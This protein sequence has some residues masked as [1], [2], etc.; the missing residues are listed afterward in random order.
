[1]TLVGRIEI[2]DRRA[3]LRVSA[4]GLSDI[5]G[6]VLIDIRTGANGRHF[7]LGRFGQAV[8]CRGPARDPGADRGSVP[9]RGEAALR[10][11]RCDFRRAGGLRLPGDGALWL[12]D[13]PSATD[14]DLRTG[15]ADRVME[16][17][18][19]P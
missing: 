7:L 1:M 4:L 3:K 2:H 11:S 13:P 5:A 9:R 10:P 15:H 14:P 8:F 17:R 19:A 12:C 6:E 16:G 18:V